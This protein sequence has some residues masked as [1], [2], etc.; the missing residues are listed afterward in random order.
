[1]TT[2]LLNPAPPLNDNYLWIPEGVTDNVV[3]G[4]D[5]ESTYIQSK[6]AA[7]NAL[8]HSTI[9]TTS[10]STLFIMKYI[11]FKLKYIIQKLLVKEM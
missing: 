8:Q 6:C 4:L 2:F 7:I 3:P 1:M 11:V 10:I 5:A 9:S